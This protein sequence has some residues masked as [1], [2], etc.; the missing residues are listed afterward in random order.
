MVFLLLKGNNLYFS[1]SEKHFKEDEY[2][3]CLE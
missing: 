2:I 3:N 1:E